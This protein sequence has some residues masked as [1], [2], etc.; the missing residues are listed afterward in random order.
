[1]TINNET[2]T[3]AGAITFDQ[4]NWPSIYGANDSDTDELPI[5]YSAA[6]APQTDTVN[7]DVAE[8]VFTIGWD[9]SEPFVLTDYYTFTDDP[10]T[11]G[12]KVGLTS[13]FKD[14][15]YRSR[16][17]NIGMNAGQRQYKCWYPG[18]PIPAIP[19]TY[20]GKPVTNINYMFALAHP[21]DMIWTEDGHSFGAIDL[22]LCD[23]SNVVSMQG[24]FYK[25]YVDFV[26]LPKYTSSKVTDMSYMFGNNNYSIKNP[27]IDLSDF[28]LTNINIS[29]IFN[30]SALQ[31]TV[32]YV[33]NTTSKEK[34]ESLYSQITF[35][36]KS[37]D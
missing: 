17:N 37:A 6:V 15:L 34:L 5:I 2:T 11:G 18:N 27:S 26:T 8:V 33:K 24:L 12:W 20:K 23:F 22:S 29:S 10:E 30:G 28:D 35:E 36:I 21:D 31:D 9:Y 25:S 3:E 7:T 16:S 1:M 13:S 32:V 14:A 4:E 19:S